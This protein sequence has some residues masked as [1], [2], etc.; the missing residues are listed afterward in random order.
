MEIIKVFTYRMRLVRE[1][2]RT[3]FLW[4]ERRFMALS[5]GFAKMSP[6]VTAPMGVPRWTASGLREAGP[7]TGAER[8][9]NIIVGGRV[10]GT[11]HAA[12]VLVDAETRGIRVG[13]HLAEGRIDGRNRA[14]SKGEVISEGKHIKG[15]GGRGTAGQ[16]G[17]RGKNGPL[18]RRG[19]IG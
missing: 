5:S 6:R 16:E 18:P 2:G 3:M 19:R 1:S 12:L 17:R 14:R 8:G 11:D 9:N 4:A 15:V 7:R 10:T 13:I